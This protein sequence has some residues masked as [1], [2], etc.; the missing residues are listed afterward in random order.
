MQKD[1]TIA[2]TEPQTRMKDFFK[3]KREAAT[4]VKRTKRKEA[5]VEEEIEDSE[6]EAPDVSEEGSSRSSAPSGFS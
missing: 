2:I 4:F 6:S 3:T 5:I 1:G